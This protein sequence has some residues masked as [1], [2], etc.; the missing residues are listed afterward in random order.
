MDLLTTSGIVKS[1]L[2]SRIGSDIITIDTNR[3][4]L[5]N[6]QADNNER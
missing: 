4:H 3:Y 2:T 5:V 6:Y 1:H